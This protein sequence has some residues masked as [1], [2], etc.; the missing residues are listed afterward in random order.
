MIIDTVIFDMDGIIVD[1]E[2]LWKQA[3]NEVFALYNIQ[4]SQEQY[5]ATTGMRTKE[6]LQYWFAFFRIDESEISVAEEKIVNLVIEKVKQQQP[7]FKGVKYIF[8]FFKTRG[9]K[10][11]LATSSP[12][13]LIDAVTS[14]AGVKDYLQVVSSAEFCEYGKPHPEVYLTCARQLNSR[15]QQCICFEDSINGMISAKAAKMKCVVVPA[16]EQ[17]KDMR[18]ALADLQLSSLLNFNDILLSKLMHV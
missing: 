6:F 18:W 3:A 13:A 10:I 16:P 8:E 5:V 17:S 4:I 14:I 2:P 12:P 9:F 1:S 11:G 7:V 15:P